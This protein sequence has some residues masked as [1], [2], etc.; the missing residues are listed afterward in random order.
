VK[1]YEWNSYSNSTHVPMEFAGKD[2]NHMKAG[3][4]R[5]N[6]KYRILQASSVDASPAASN[7]D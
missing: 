1:K 7:T 6:R 3:S 4:V 5:D 2:V